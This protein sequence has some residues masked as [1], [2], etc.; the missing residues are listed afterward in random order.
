MADDALN[1]L[2]A[3][4][5]TATLRSRD[6]GSGVQAQAVDVGPWV[7][8][9]AAT[10]DNVYNQTV[11]SSVVTLTTPSGSTHVLVS[12]ENDAVRYKEDGANP[13]ATSGILLPDGF[14]GELPCPTSLKFI[15]VT[16]D[17]VINASF[18]SYV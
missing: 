6:V 17:A 2:S 7:P 15:R 18:R 3:D 14:I 8:T 5:S 10:A 16:T 9:V 12:V 13:S 11:S 4:S 1:V